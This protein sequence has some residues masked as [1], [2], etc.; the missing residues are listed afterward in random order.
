VQT[1]TLTRTAMTDDVTFGKLSLPWCD[2]TCMTLELP[3]RDNASNIS[4]I[5][6]GIYDLSPVH[7]RTFGSILAVD[8]VPSRSLVRVHAGNHTGHTHGCI[9]TGKRIGH[10]KGRPFIFNSRDALRV[11]VSQVRALYDSGDSC[12]LEVLNA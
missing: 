6:E 8:G 9:L 12:Q 10:L 5:P 2:V 1:A 3:W 7:S 11:I 4:C